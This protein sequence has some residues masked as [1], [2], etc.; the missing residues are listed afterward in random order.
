[1]RSFRRACSEDSDTSISLSSSCQE[2][3]GKEEE[4]EAKEGGEKLQ[5]PL[6]ESSEEER[7]CPPTSWTGKEKGQR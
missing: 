6:V 3:E 7:S 4:K 2:K 5:S 1:M